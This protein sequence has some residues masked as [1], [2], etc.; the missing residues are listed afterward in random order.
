MSKKLSK[1]EIN[2]FIEMLRKAESVTVNYSPPIPD[3]DE[4]YDIKK[5]CLIHWRAYVEF[6]IR[7]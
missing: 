3:I 1:K 4:F 6:S 2:E 7:S 5:D